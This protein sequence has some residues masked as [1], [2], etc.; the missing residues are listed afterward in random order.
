MGTIGESYHMPTNNQKHDKKSIEAVD[1]NEEISIL[2]NEQ[3][4]YSN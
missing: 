2:E 1:E 4:K 3:N